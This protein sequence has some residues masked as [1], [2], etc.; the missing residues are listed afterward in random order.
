MTSRRLTVWF[1]CSKLEEDVDIVMS[2]ELRKSEVSLLI[3]ERQSVIEH[4][5]IVGMLRRDKSASHRVL[6]PPSVLDLV[7]IVFSVE[8]ELLKVAVKVLHRRNERVARKNCSDVEAC[9]IQ[10]AV[11]AKYFG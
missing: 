2:L 4:Q 7:E 1:C 6:G 8:D 5:R 10:E 9:V 3:L 11:A